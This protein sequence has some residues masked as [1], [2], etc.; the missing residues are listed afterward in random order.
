MKKY[1]FTEHTADSGVRVYGKTLD[2]LFVNAAGAVSSLLVEKAFGK[3]AERAFSL[4]A[5]TFED[6]LIAWLNELISLFF[7]FSFFPQKYEVG[8]V[9]EGKGMRL[10]G[11]VYGIDIDYTCTTMNMEVKAATYH[12]LRIKRDKE[13]YETEIILDV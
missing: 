9:C 8:V 13:G 6:L 3:P 2:E 7:T 1:E 5:E 10:K 11:M 4:Y 12:N